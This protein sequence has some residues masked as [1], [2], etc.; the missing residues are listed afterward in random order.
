MKPSYA[1][2]EYEVFCDMATDGGGWLVIY[3]YL[4]C[5]LIEIAR[6]VIVRRHGLL[7][8]RSSS[9]VFDKTSSNWSARKAPNFSA[10]HWSQHGSLVFI[11]QHLCLYHST[12]TEFE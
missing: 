8:K 2:K 1:H 11:G 3:V 7:Y 6:P 10:F 12:P 9:F 5:V 4:R